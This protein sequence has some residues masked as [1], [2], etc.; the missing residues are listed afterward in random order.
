MVVGGDRAGDKD[1]V[2]PAQARRPHE[3]ADQGQVQEGS[4]LGEIPKLLRRRF[5]LARRFR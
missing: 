3:G 5:E 1:D 4:V 2:L